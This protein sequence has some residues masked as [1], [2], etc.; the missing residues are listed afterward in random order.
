MIRIFGKGNSVQGKKL[1]DALPELEGQPYLNLLD[2]VY[3]TGIAYQST[4]APSQLVVDG[5]L[6]TYYFDF[7]SPPLFDENNQVYG[8][9]DMAVDVTKRVKASRLK[10]NQNSFTSVSLSVVIKSVL[11]DLELVIVEKTAVIEIETPA[12]VWGDVSQLSQ[13]FLN[14]ISNALKYQ[15]SGQVPHIRIKSLLLIFPKLAP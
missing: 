8:I 9:L 5:Q 6:A 2:Q 12:S 4:N 1:K 13:L 11:S 3:Q 14:L 10:A 7:S 15:P